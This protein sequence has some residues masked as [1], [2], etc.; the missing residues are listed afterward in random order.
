MQLSKAL[1]EREAQPGPMLLAG[2]LGI[3]LAESLE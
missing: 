1:R 3:Q 2:E